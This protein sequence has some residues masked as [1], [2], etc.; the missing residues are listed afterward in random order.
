[1]SHIHGNIPAPNPDFPQNVKTVTGNNNIVIS[2]K[3]LYKATSKTTTIGGVSATITD[4]YK[5]VLNGTATS[6][7]T[8][9]ISSSVGGDTIN[10]MLVG[11]V[12]S[13]SCT[14]SNN[15]TPYKMW[16]GYFDANNGAHN[17]FTGMWN[18]DDI[19]GVKKAENK[20]MNSDA[21]AY[22]TVV[23][24]VN[25]TRYDNFEID[26]QI[27]LN[28]VAT[29][30]VVPASQTYPLSLGSIEL[31]K[32]ETYQDYITGTIDNWKVVKNIKKIILDGDTDFTKA[33]TQEVFYKANLVTDATKTGI[34]IMST[35]FVGKTTVG[36]A[37]TMA[38]NPDNSIALTS[39]TDGRLYIKATQF[40][41]ATALDT[42]LANNNVTCYYE[43]ETPTE[44]T[45]TDTT[46]I[47]QLN[48]I[49]NARSYAG[50]TNIT[51]TYANEQMIISAT[52]LTQMG[53]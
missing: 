32:I 43:L 29:S 36:S 1:M 38:S 39:S 27:E 14:P 19:T 50:Q 11:N 37:S 6:T 13:Y 42:Y 5:I 52:A 51:S 10:K 35:A 7:A 26:L 33:T 3:N 8:S 18:S 47:S 2:N 24:V 48:A 22:R 17:G 45:I 53:V 28:S 44:E 31:A 9:I 15:T 34:N 20:T 4:G 25:G 49:Y 40:A 30:Y 46:L 16:F 41:D 12:V 21:V 23:G